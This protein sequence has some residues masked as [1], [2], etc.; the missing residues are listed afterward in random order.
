MRKGLDRARH[1]WTQEADRK[2]VE[3]VQVY[4]RENWGLGQS[5]V[6]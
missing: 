3:G 5:I 4:G 6:V 1:A 2:L